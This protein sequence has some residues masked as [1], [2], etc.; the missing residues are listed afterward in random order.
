MLTATLPLSALVSVTNLTFVSNV[1]ACILGVG[2]AAL[3]GYFFSPMVVV[4]Q[5]RW[6]TGVDGSMFCDIVLVLQGQRLQE[7]KMINKSIAALGNCVAAL[8]GASPR[9]GRMTVS[10]VFNGSSTTAAAHDLGLPVRLCARLMSCCGQ[11]EQSAARHCTC[12]FE[13]PC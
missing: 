6:F 11:S 4:N 1:A 5:S 2:V 12:H 3:L 13:T 7:A 9:L 8:A 10:L